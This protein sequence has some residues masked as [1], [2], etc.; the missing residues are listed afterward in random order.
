MIVKMSKYTFVLYH[1]RQKEFLEDLQELGLVDIT[2][3]GWEPD[4]RERDMLISLEQ[5]R[6]AGAYFK[7]LAKDVNFT[8]G[9]PFGSG[10]EAFEAYLKATAETDNLRG[11]IE[12]ARKEASDLEIWGE[13]SPGSISDLASKGITLRFFSVYS[14]EFEKLKEKYGEELIIEKIAEH[15]GATYFVVVQYEPAAIPFDAQEYK[16][17]EMTASQ[18]EAQVL[19]L[20]EKLKEQDEIMARAAAS[21]DMIENNGER[22]RERL[23]FSRASR[24]GEWAAEDT[25]VVMEAWATEE[26]SPEVDSML[27]KWPDVVYFKEK[28]TD[29]D[30]APVVLKNKKGVSPFE[31]IGNFYSLPRYGTLDLTTFFAPFYMIFFGICLG[32]AGYGLIMLL[33]GFFLMR[34][35]KPVMKQ[36]GKL[37]VMCGAAAVVIGFLTG[38][39]FGI[40]LPE[41]AMFEGIRNIFLTTDNLFALA[42]ILGIVQ[43]YFA[44]IL[45]VVNTTISRGF[46]YSL[47]TIGWMMVVPYFA[48][49]LLGMLVPDLGV[50]VNFSSPVN[51]AV[52]IAGVILMLFFHN[53]DKKPWINVGSGLW[54][55]YNDVTGFLGDFLSY[56]RLFALCMS[57]GTLA[58]VFNQ[59]AFGMTDGMSLIPR[60][61]VAV[62]ILAIGHGINLF[63]S[64]LGAFVHPMRLTFVEFYKNAGF[65]ATQR[66]FSPLKKATNDQINN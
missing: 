41:V 17:P 51:L 2:S 7:E 16:S 4:E 20:E 28:P 29:K 42:L 34:N 65:E 11:L 30:D 36:V 39:F 66:E 53:P 33:G 1:K 55:T 43:I 31:F 27:E 45:K 56:I 37:T 19:S 13:F 40:S 54:N 10:E 59:L 25:L 12:K 32:D 6:A 64:F 15:D 18:K 62:I 23:D 44:L 57:G 58:L 21:A 46:K 3:T 50:S 35:K 49:L 22:I 24:S 63:M 9:K 14:N 61:L 26:T 8:P 48:L 60:I 5:H 47:G 52:M 38:G